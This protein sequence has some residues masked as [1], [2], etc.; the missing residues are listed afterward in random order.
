MPRPSR[1]TVWI[2]GRVVGTN[3]VPISGASASAYKGGRAE[4]ATAGMDPMS[5]SSTITGTDGIFEMCSGMFSVGDSA[6]IRINRKGLPPIEQIHRL[7]DTLFVLPLI[8]D[9]RRP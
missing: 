5:V 8:R 6:L 1:Q 7:T 9:P 4:I 3:N 2:I